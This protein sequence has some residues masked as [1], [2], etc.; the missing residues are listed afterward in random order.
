M[1]GREGLLRLAR[2]ARE[3]MEDCLH[4]REAGE[5]RQD[6]RGALA[7]VD[8]GR[9]AEI[10]SHLQHLFKDR[11]LEQTP[12]GRL[13]AVFRGMVI[14]EPDLADCDDF[15]AGR[16]IPEALPPV[17]GAWFVD[18][19]GVN[20][21]CGKDAGMGGGEPEIGFDVFEITGNRNDPPDAGFA[22]TGEDSRHFPG[23]PG[24]GEVGMGVGQK[25]FR[26]FFHRFAV[27]L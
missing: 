4:C 10:L 5:D 2:G 3:T 12:G 15:G 7:R 18:I 13:A 8:H 16:E 14:I 17:R 25:N 6:R 1:A 24:R 22:G 26:F 27:P 11:L 20:P 19:A 23:K 9:Q 21:R